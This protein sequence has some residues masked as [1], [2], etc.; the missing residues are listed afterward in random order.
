MQCN[1]PANRASDDI[2]LCCHTCDWNTLGTYIQ[3]LLFLV[4]P[5]H[6]YK[7]QLCPHTNLNK[8]VSK[9]LIMMRQKTWC[10][11]IIIMMSTSP[12]YQF[13]PAQR[14]HKTRP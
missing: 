14:G 10:V 13:L 8:M 2:M 4:T 6:L 9:T 12:K 1:V 11:V 5:H 7:F 3:V